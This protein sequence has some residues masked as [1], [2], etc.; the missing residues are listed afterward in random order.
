MTT[1][2]VVLMTRNRTEF[3]REALESALAQTHDDLE[4]VVSDNS[5]THSVRGVVAEYADPRLCYRHN[6]EDIGATRS[7]LAGM[8]RLRTE[9]AALLH[10]DDRW[11]PTFIEHLLE[12]HRHDRALDASFCDHLFIDETGRPLPRY[13]ARVEQMRLRGIP[14]GAVSLADPAARAAVLCRGAIQPC[15]GALFRRAFVTDRSCPDLFGVLYDLW[16]RYELA[17]TESRVA[18]VAERLVRFRLHRRSLTQ[19][20]PSVVNEIAAFEMFLREPSFADLHDE[21]EFWLGQFRLRHARRLLVERRYDDA[22]ELLRRAA[23]EVPI[24]RRWFAAF[25]AR[26]AP[27]PQIARVAAIGHQALSRHRSVPRR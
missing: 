7:Y 18:H 24:A 27:A 22:A 17:L 13:T 10:D 16:L 20:S 19:T 26:S 9:H 6:G 11:E 1:V 4:I 8:S 3:L 12:P 21:I 2:G 14:P 15:Y 23:P 5:T 25:A